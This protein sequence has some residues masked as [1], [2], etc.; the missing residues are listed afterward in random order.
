M[1]KKSKVAYMQLTQPGLETLIISID[2]KISEALSCIDSNTMGIALIVDDNGKLLHTITDG[3]I[4]RGILAGTSVDATTTELFNRK[5]GTNDNAPITAPVGTSLDDALNIMHK[6]GIR[7]LPLL[8]RQ[9]KL[10]NIITLDDILRKKHLPVQAVVMAG[11]FGTRLQP[12]TNTTPKPMLPLGNKP[13][14]ERIV[15]KFAD[16]GIQDVKITTHFF[17]DK[18][19]NYFSDGS[20]FGVSI[21]YVDESHPL[22]T[23]GSLGLMD[24]PDMPL[25]VVNG[26]ILT[27]VNFH[28]LFEFHQLHNADLTIGCRQYEFSIPYGVLK[29]DD[30]N[31]T[32]VQEKPSYPFLVNAGV[33]LVNP[34]IHD[35][36]TKNE[37]LDMPD[38]ITRAIAK[39]KKVVSFPI[40]EYWSDVGQHDTYKQA[41]LD[42]SNGKIAA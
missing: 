17:P 9:G 27:D 21:E 14:L 24:K 38:L 4:R 37:Y 6:N 31:V 5:D 25:L 20:D 3:D 41:N 12:L 16:V 19:R 13:M 40:L 22:G 10:K 28:S 36:V 42:I 29:C 2:S 33:Y 15:R 26:D 7:H 32:E 11:G 35:L 8:D 34:D 30:V 1:S 23:A 18:I 39:G